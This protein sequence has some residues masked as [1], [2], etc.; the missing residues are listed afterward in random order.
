LNQGLQLRRLGVPPPIELPQALEIFVPAEGRG[1]FQMGS[2]VIQFTP[3]DLVVVD[4]SKLHGLLEFEGGTQRGIAVIFAPEFVYRPG[5]LPSDLAF[6]APFQGLLSDPIRMRSEGSRECEIATA[7]S[8]LVSCWI[9]SGGRSTPHLGCKV[10]LFELLYLIS[11]RIRPAHDAEVEYA[12]RQKEEAF[13]WRLHDH[14]AARITER[15]SVSDAAEFA[16]MQRFAFMR[17]FRH[18]TGVT[19]IAYLTQLRLDKATRLL[20]GTDE[21]IGSIA[22]A[23]GFCDQSYMDRVFQRH[24]GCTPREMRVRLR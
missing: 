1:R 14:F 20:M 4:N 21:P 8:R 11:E 23:A 3:G 15:I 13:L 5:S 9:A 2:R 18:V 16:G 22:A 7:L 17:Y 6:L 19:F 24:Y 12:R 10:Y